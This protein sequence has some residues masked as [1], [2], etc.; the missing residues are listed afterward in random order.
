MVF[1]SQSAP[2]LDCLVVARPNRKLWQIWKRRLLFTSKTCLGLPTA[3][4]IGVT[5]TVNY[6][7]R[8]RQFGQFALWLV[9]I[10]EL[11]IRHVKYSAHVPLQYIVAKVRYC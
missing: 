4:V 2:I 8:Y 5:D 11:L 1:S 6:V 7:K 9:L 10:S 3:S